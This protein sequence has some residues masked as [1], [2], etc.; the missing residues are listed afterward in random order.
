MNDS[1][2]NLICVVVPVFNEAEVLPLFFKELLQIAPELK[3]KMSVLFV[4]DG[5]IDDS[6]KII[7]DYCG[8]HDFVQM[9]SLSRNFGKEAAMSA[10]LDYAKGDAVVVI[11]ADLQ[12]PP[13][14][15]VDMERLWLSG[16][17]VVYA[18]RRSRSGE[19][20]FRK[21]FA[22]I[23]YR[24]LNS[25]SDF[26]IPE[27]TGDFRLLSKKVVD[28]LRRCRE[29]NRYMKG[30]FA[31]VGF[32]QKEILFDRDPRMAGKSKWG[33]PKLFGLA[34]SGITSFSAA[35]LRLATWIGFLCAVGCVFYAFW[36]FGKTLLFG[37][38]VQGFPTLIVAVLFLGGTQLIALGI[39][40]EYIGQIYDE[41]KQ[42]PMYLIDKGQ[43]SSHFSV[44]DELS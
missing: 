43:C 8:Q 9:L 17:D 7:L 2:D 20:F 24:L 11:D 16:E 41:L 26:P 4:D 1:K 38:P 6:R 27:D 29:R 39:T 33:L 25:L 22:Q 37:D 3:S 5:S 35:P 40:G 10:G 21:F 36:F 19:P 34:F 42:R 44:V 23:Y 32:R 30:L 18:K 12:D 14:L 15:I 28:A 13:S 31:W